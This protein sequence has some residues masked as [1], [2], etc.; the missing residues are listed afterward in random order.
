MGEHMRESRHEEVARDTCELIREGVGATDI[1]HGAVTAASPFLNV[2]AHSMMTAKGEVRPVNYDHTVLAF[3][4]AER[5][6]R[7]LARQYRH[8]PLAQAAWYLPQGLDIWSQ[9]LCEFP[10]HYS[11]EQEKC[12]TINLKGPKQHFEEHPPLSEG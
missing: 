3:W 5:M 9:I 7:M 2:P 4:R 11:R 10:G 12:P 6:G 8:L 1:G